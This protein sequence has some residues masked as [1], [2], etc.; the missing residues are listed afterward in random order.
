MIFSYD[1][2]WV[3]RVLRESRVLDDEDGALAAEAWQSL[4]RL[5]SYVALSLDTT[6]DERTNQRL[7]ECRNRSRCFVYD[8]RHYT[9]DNS[10]GP[11][12]DGGG[13]NWVHIESL[14]NVILM[15][16]RELPGSQNHPSPPLGL[17]ATRAYSAPMGCSSKDDWAGIEGEFS[18]FQQAK[19]V[20][21]SAR[22][23]AKIC[24]FHGLSVCYLSDEQCHSSSLFSPVIC[25]VRCRL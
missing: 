24:L 6:N 12:L 18:S 23:L 3:E 25:S 17:Q 19:Y 13:V 10:W 21:T 20:L 8:L 11:Y 1:L 16:L 15:N 9:F 7:K 5:R 14:I 4:A 2:R 22:N